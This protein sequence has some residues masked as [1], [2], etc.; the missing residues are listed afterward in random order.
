ML[1]KR[2]KKRDTR[3]GYARIEIADERVKGKFEICVFLDWVYSTF[4]SI[5]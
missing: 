4:I 2:E 3:V 1:R 5:R